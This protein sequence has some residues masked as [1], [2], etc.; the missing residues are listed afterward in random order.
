MMV[1]KWWGYLVVGGWSY[2]LEGGECGK[3]SDLPRKKKRFG[4]GG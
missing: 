3:I 2:D 4:E 1:G